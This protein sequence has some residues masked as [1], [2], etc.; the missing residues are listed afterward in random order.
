ML[1]LAPPSYVRAR[2]AK[3][4]TGNSTLPPWTD[5]SIE[6][7]PGRS[8]GFLVVLGRSRTDGL[9]GRH[10]VPRQCPR[11]PRSPPMASRQ[12]GAPPEVVAAT[13]MMLEEGIEDDEE[14]AAAHLLEL[15]L[16]LSSCAPPP[17]DR[18]DRV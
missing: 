6:L 8:R 11:P 9:L 18:R 4:Q 5:P 13:Q 15:E 1:R 2:S 14:I 7:S 17:L 12:L 3:V 16:R 10:G